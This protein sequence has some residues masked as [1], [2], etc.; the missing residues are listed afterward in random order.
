[1]HLVVY[2]IQNLVILVIYN[3]N[4]YLTKRETGCECGVVNDALQII[5]IITLFNTDFVVFVGEQYCTF[6]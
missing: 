4:Y 5:F 1:M 6:H 2:I 3:K